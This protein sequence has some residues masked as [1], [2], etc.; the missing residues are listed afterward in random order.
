MTEVERTLAITQQPGTSGSVLLRVE[1]ELDHH[2]AGQLREAFASVPFG[3][4][5]GVVV[6]LS[7]LEY[8]DSTGL[9]V[10]ITA[11]HRATSAGSTLSIVGLRPGL[12]RVFRIA[13]IDQVIS[14]YPT[15]DHA[16]DRL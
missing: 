15:L 10:L 6:D 9:T 2:T 11:Y 8:C 7:G 5:R 1:G 16:L 12:E 13:G 3:T 14:L 4:S